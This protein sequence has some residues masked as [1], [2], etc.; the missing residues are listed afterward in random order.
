MEPRFQLVHRGRFFGPFTNEQIERLRQM[1]LLPK[2]G[3]IL[4]LPAPPP[5]T[6]L[7]GIPA[8]ASDSQRPWTPPPPPAPAPQ[9]EGTEP[10]VPGQPPP[11][12]PA[13]RTTAA[14]PTGF[15][16]QPTPL[17]LAPALELPPTAPVP[18]P[19]PAPPKAVGPT[20]EADIADFAPLPGPPEPGPSGDDVT[21]AAEADNLQPVAEPGDT[22]L[23][24]PAAPR[25]RTWGPVLLGLLCGLA[26]IAAILW[27]APYLRHP[28]DSNEAQRLAEQ[29][30]RQFQEG[31]LSQTLLSLNR[32]ASITAQPSNVWFR[33]GQITEQLT[34]LDAG[35]YSASSVE[36]LRR[37]WLAEREQLIRG[38]M[39]VEALTNALLVADMTNA[40][41]GALRLL[42]KAATLQQDP[43]TIEAIRQL[44]DARARQRADR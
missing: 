24:V 32:L 14:A 44:I 41:E 22:P 2:D 38:V 3:T 17:T 29:A 30:D 26:A 35:S 13:D 27:G 9:P 28:V 43:S 4:P 15:A 20:V 12:P 39:F 21:P 31:D 1:G 19:V 40:T 7:E 8:G 18:A 37:Q 36:T 11:A 34:A 16:V 33:I 5:A 10:E 25:S 42:E 6:P 23:P